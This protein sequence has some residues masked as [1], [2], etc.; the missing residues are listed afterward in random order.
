MLKTDET[1]NGGH[2]GGDQGIIRE[3]YQYLGGSYD[4]FRAADIDISV[5]NHFLCFAAEEARRGSLVV[6]MDEYMA[7]YGWKNR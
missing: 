1:I 5:R 6:D 4:G 7:R 3:L 2:G